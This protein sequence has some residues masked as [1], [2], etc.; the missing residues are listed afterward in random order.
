M[1]ILLL[2][3]I[4]ASKMPIVI[5]NLGL[6]YL[7]SALRQDGHSISMLDCNKEHLTFADLST[8]LGQKSY[9][10]IGIQVYSCDLSTAKR[11]IEII[12]QISPH[13]TVV[14]GGPH[15]TALP[16][17]SLTFL[18]ADLAI[19]GEALYSFPKLVAWL[20]EG[21]RNPPA[22]IEGL[23]HKQDSRILRNAPGYIKNLDDLGFPSW[24]LM[25]P[26]TYP[27]AP[28]GAF[29]RAFPTAP[30]IVSRG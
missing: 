5:P 1:K 15:S 7:A 28:F 8:Y 20:G 18:G 29:A 24:D 9:S 2:N 26:R 25:D 6:G 4:S 10:L 27:P 12:K 11:T 19:A 30:L 13:T 16:E 17:Q 3:P 23:V 14:V 22:N 21:S